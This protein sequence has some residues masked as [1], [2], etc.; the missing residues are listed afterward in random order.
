M[1]SDAKPN[2]SVRFVEWRSHEAEAV[3]LIRFRVFVDEQKVPAE[4]ELDEIDGAAMHLLAANGLGEP[5]GTGRLF[6]DPDNPSQGKIGRMA[7]LKQRRG[8]GCGAAILSALVN[9]ARKQQ[10][11]VVTLSAQLHAVPF[12]QRFGFE[13]VGPLYDD[14]GIPHQAM[15]LLL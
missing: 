1:P 7:V 3:K 4:L 11:V 12:Y 6:A 13:S 8:T 9:E 5:C 14:A 2:Y 15:T 10:Y